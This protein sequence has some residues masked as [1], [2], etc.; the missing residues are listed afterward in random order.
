MVGVAVGVNDIE[1]VF[2]ALGGITISA[3]APLLPC[4]FYFSLVIQK[5]QP[6]GCKFY[7]S[8]IIFSIMT[9][10]SLFSVISLYIN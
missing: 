10:Y 8:I 3:L 2:N 7:L 5:K 6:K 1:V 9:P 4:L